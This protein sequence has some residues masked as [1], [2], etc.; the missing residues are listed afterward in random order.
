MT[1]LAGSLLGWLLVRALD[2][3]PFSVAGA[4]MPVAVGC[5]AGAL[6][7]AA[8]L[9]VRSDLLV[10][11]GVGAYAAWAAL[12]MATALHGTP[13]GYGGM[14][15]DEGRLVAM[16]TK[17]MSSTS[18]VDGFV[19]HVPTEYPP[20]YPWLIGHVADLFGRPAW[21]VVGEAQVI[22][23]S[24]AI[25]TSYCLW[26]RL[27]GARTA[28][29]IVALAPAIYAEPSKAHEVVTLLVIVPW[30][31]ATFTGLAHERGGM[32]WLP[33]GMIGGLMVLTYPGYLGFALV[34]IVAMIVL[35][36]RAAP[37]RRSYLL[38]LTGVTITAF[39]VASWYVVPYVAR[40]LT[41]GGSQISDLFL[42]SA[43]VAEPVSLPFL[44]PTVLGLIELVGLVG[45]VWYRRST[46]W[47]QPLLLLLISG[48]AYRVLF[49]LRIVQNDHTGYLHYTERLIG[50]V[51]ATAG[52]L[53]VVATAPALMRRLAA[54]VTRQREVALLAVAIVVLWTAVQGWQLWTPGPRGIRNAVGPAVGTRNL[55]TLAHTEPLP[56]GGRTRFAPPGIT[57]QPVFPSTAVQHVITSTLG[58]GARPVTLSED[59]R[60][61][62]YYPDYA[63][64]PPDR[65]AANALQRWDD[66]ARAVRRLAQ[67][68]DPATF[69]EASARTSFGG[70]DVFVL[71]D[72]GNA[73]TW[74]DIRFDPAAFGTTFFH[75]V[76]LPH[77][78]V[79]AVRLRP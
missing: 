30:A 25:V 10:G 24:G 57:V 41:D 44:Q 23:T 9:R 13:F 71:R 76:R 77:S 46:W 6:L 19:R 20:L 60:L 66:R 39:V 4:V 36:A 79:V 8:R 58:P 27:V 65:L 70:I 78:V 51:L 14:Q 12:T 38:H 11:V 29:L 7:L 54:P 26:R 75:V 35:A 21:Q 69:A 48:F 28:F 63:Y 45:I 31:L 72:G 22:V 68:Q 50:T 32:H 73:W 33:A 42:S 1:W 52:I 34:G 16:A 40:S 17:Y 61:F 18:A 37:M 49:L 59:Q 2:L 56:T 74:N 5:V 3:D 67:I 62:S 47:A 53:T 43:I 64:L 15:G 55:A